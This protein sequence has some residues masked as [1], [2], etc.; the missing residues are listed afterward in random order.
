MVVSRDHD[1][2]APLAL[3]MKTSARLGTEVV[4]SDMGASKSSKIWL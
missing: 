3:S 1:G 4:L 2:E